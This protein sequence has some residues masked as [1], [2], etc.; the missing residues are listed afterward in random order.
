MS[1]IIA[2]VFVTKKSD[3]NICPILKGYGVMKA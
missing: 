2:Y 3:I 1:D